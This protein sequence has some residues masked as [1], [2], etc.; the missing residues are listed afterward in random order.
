MKD[1]AP[2]R[3]AARASL[4]AIGLVLAL[5]A[6]EAAF[7]LVPF[8]RWKYEVRYGHF[9]G[10]TVSR[11]LEYDPELTF[12]N[13]RGLHDSGVDID[14]LGLRGP[15][16]AVEKAPGE[17]R[18]L[19]LGDSCTF[20]GA[21]PYPEFLQAILDRRYDPGRVEVLNAGVIGYTSLHGLRWF[22]RDLEPLRPDVVVVYF[23]WNDMWR[24]F[25]SA[26]RDWFRRDVAGQG[27]PFRSYL[28]EAAARSWSFLKNRAQ[29]GEVPLQVPPD[30]YRRILEEFA[31]LGARDSFTTIY[32]A[33][34]SGF[35]D[36][37]TPQWMIDKG[38]V[39]RGDSAPALRRRYNDV[40]REVAAAR[41]LPLAA[42]DV[43]F[44]AAGGRA[45]FARPDEDP[46][47]PNER[48]YQRIATVVADAIAAS[49]GR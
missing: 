34:P 24:V 10:N 48:G 27:W 15:E 23:G 30:R 33:A 7:R 36:D 29:A 12:R 14:A 38:F 3:L 13:R 41:G 28:F 47:H 32:V 45:L 49:L 35:D 20:G 16:V 17:K 42:C 43:D 37:R 8:E 46:I 21:H 5:A 31:D 44:A 1:R 6:G 39:A 22:R 4:V 19:C 18:V 11:F 9:S 40:V 2:N 26:I 25:D